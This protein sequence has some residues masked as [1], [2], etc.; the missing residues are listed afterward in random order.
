MFSFYASVVCPKCGTINTI[1][2]FTDEPIMFNCKSCM[3]GLE[4]QI[5][6]PEQNENKES[7]PVED[8]DILGNY[9]EKPK[10]TKKSKK[11][12]E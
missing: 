10:K 7:D 12:I 11:E 2:V 9:V 4:Y 6:E 5:P 1:H 3:L 8:K